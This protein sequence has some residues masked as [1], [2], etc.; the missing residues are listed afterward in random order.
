[1][2]G[3]QITQAAN[4]LR[5]F[6]RSLPPD[7]YFNVVGFGSSHQFLFKESVKYDNKS[8]AKATTHAQSLQ[9]DLGGTELLDPMQAIL[10]RPQIKGYPRQVFVLTDGQISN[11]DQV[12]GLVTKHSDTTRVFALGIGHS[13]SRHLVEGLARAGKGTA[14]F[15]VDGK[16]M[17]A[18]VMQQLKHAIQ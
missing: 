3:S 13:V 16:S 2:Q 5:I 7:S 11:T 15:V 4:A 10:R 12:I 14:Q 17:E 6:M 9:A 1:M 18:K 8:M